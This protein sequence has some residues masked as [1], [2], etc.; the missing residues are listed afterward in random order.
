MKSHLVE[1]KKQE[2]EFLT[3]LLSG[4]ILQNYGIPI[5]IK[6][7]LRKYQQ[8]STRN[9]TALSQTTSHVSTLSIEVIVTRSL[10]WHSFTCQIVGWRELASF[11]KQV[12]ATR[13]IVWWYGTRKD[14]AI[15]MHY[16]WRSLH[17]SK[18]IPGLIVLLYL[19]QSPETVH[20]TFILD[21]VGIGALADVYIMVIFAWR[22]L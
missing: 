3:Q 22:R 14:P 4:N 5:P 21:F 16:S 11:L 18:E 9:S 1:K 13:N 12:Q 2:R 8:V 20:K 17:A 19:H 10:Y 15:H 7:D 6:A